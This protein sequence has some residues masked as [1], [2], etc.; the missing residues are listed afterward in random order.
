MVTNLLPIPVRDREQIRTQATTLST[1][2]I[3]DD[4]RLAF[5][6]AYDLETKGRMQWRSGFARL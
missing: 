1:Y 2:R 3:G 5:V 4:G 6:R